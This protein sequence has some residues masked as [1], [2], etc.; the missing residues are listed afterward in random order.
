MKKVSFLDFKAIFPVILQIFDLECHGQTSLK[1]AFVMFGLVLRKFRKLKS[2]DQ[3]NKKLNLY[4]FRYFHCLSNSL[5]H[6]AEI[7]FKISF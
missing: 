1:A 5:Y 4:K 3:E 6:G 2:V 7:V